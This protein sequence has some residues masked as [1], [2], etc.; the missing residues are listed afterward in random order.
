MFR[1][2]WLPSSSSNNNI[3]NK[4]WWW[5]HRRLYIYLNTPS[6]R[7]NTWVLLIHSEIHLAILRMQIHNKGTIVY[8][9]NTIGHL[10]RIFFYSLVSVD[11]LAVN[12]QVV[13]SLLIVWIVNVSCFVLRNSDNDFVQKTTLFWSIKENCFTLPLVDFPPLLFSVILPSQLLQSNLGYPLN[14]SKGKRT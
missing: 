14:L 10:L 2:P 1:W 5:H 8:C 9:R 12:F 6:S 7:F 4:T 13:H 11:S 3:I